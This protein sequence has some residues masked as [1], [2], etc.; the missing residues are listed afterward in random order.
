MAPAEIQTLVVLL[1][2]DHLRAPLRSITPQRSQHRCRFLLHGRD[3]GL[4]EFDPVETF[5]MIGKRLGRTVRM[6]IFA[7]TA[8]KP[9][10]AGDAFRGGFVTGLAARLE[11]PGCARR[12]TAGAAIV[13]TRVG[14]ALAMP[15]EELE[16]FMTTHAGMTE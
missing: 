16:S 8:M 2:D 4:R 10:G 9:T 1:T 5:G 12:G 14:R 11:R 13:V 7:V 3:G 15:T 6:E